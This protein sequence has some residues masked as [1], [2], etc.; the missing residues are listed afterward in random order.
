MR[1]IKL[2]PHNLLAYEKAEHMIEKEG[3]A[4]IVHPTGTGKSFIAFAFAQNHPDKNFLWISPSEYIYDLQCKNLWQKQHIELKNI[5]FHTYAWLMRNED[6]IE[7]LEADYIILDEFHRS[8]AQEWGKS[9]DKLLK[10]H[11][12]AKLL[13]LTATKVRY[14]DA[15]RDMAEEIFEGCIASEMGICEAMALGILPKPKY[16][17]ASYSY[18]QKL[19]EYISRAATLTNEARRR[20]VEKLIEKLR[21]KLE[22]ADG[23]DKIFEKH[24]PRNDAKLIVFCRS[25]EHMMEIMAQSPDWFHNID[26]RPHIYHV[27]SYNPESES[28]FSSFVE[29]DSDHLKLLFCIDMLNEGI[30]VADVDAVVLCRPTESPIIYKQQIGR[31]IAVG[32]GKKPVIFD[33]VNNFDSL[34]QI[35]L[36]KQELYGIVLEENGEAP[37]EPGAFEVVDEL[38][39]CRDLLDSVQTHLDATWDMYYLE[40]CRYREKHDLHD[41]NDKY[42]TEDGLPL[43]R[44]LAMQKWEYHKNKLT[45]ERV[46]ALERLG[47]TWDYQNDII[48]AQNVEL[49]KKYKEEHGSFIVIS[50]NTPEER[51]LSTWIKYIREHYKA[52]TLPEERIRILNEIGFNW[53]VSDARWEEGYRHAKDYYET[54]GN[55][56]VSNG[57]TCEDGYRLA[58][59]LINQRR[60]RRG[61]VMGHMTEEKIKKLDEIS[62]DWSPKKDTYSQCL[63]AFKKYLADGGCKI[64]PPDYVTADGLSLAK[65][66]TELRSLY[67]RGKLKKDKQKQLEEAGFVFHRYT[68]PWYMHYQEAKEYFEANGDLKIKPGYK[69]KTCKNLATWITEHRNEYKKAGHGRLDEDQVKMLEEIHIDDSY[70]IEPMFEK[71]IREYRKYIDEY[72]TSL[73]LPSFKSKE[74][75]PLGSWLA[76]LRTSYRKGELAEEEISALNELGMVWDHIK[77]VGAEIHWNNMYKAALKYAEEHGSLRHMPLDYVT[78]SGEKLGTWVAQ[79]RRIRRGSLKHSIVMTEEKIKMLDN[80]GINWGKQ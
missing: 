31:A 14:L 18:E 12:D 73:V 67:Y 61:K 79:Q 27:S 26:Y 63:E 38:R 33:M 65:W 55:L 45:P 3:K 54:H 53:S 32:S 72:G 41:L 21:R 36:L 29:D 57:Y 40:L 70:R 5:T 74:G 42:K 52:G 28:E 44:W 22:M 64:I 39:D 34:Y 13:G 47:V 1:M 35:N 4:A 2:Y 50:K 8:G 7:G 71:I 77:N 69:S 68:Y 46:T 20:K 66:D 43:G 30:H 51:I 9:V 49:Y 6:I 16:V 59:W 62:F 58:Q 25:S 24:M 56:T 10:T 15:Q 80:I 23:M 48:F 76:R 75:C 11:P 37:D 60:L 17:I 78:E 19:Q